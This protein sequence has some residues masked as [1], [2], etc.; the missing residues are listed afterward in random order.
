MDQIDSLESLTP[1][2]FLADPKKY[3]ELLNTKVELRKSVTLISSLSNF[4]QLK[5]G[6]LVR[7]RGLIQDMHDPEIYLETYQVKDATEKITTRNGKFRDN[8]KLE[9]STINTICILLN[10]NYDIFPYFLFKRN[11]KKFYVSH[12]PMFTENGDQCLWYQYPA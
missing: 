8:L 3:I 1:E 11:T 6:Q 9:V 7:F 12:H 2:L 10:F 5:H 4:N